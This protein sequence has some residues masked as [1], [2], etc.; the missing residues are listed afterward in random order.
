MFSFK[1]TKSSSTEP[2]ASGWRACCDPICWEAGL[3]GEGSQALSDGPPEPQQMA[4]VS[5]T[6]PQ[7]HREVSI[8]CF[9]RVRYLHEAC[10]LP[11]FPSVAFNK[12]THTHIHTHINTLFA[13]WACRP[14]LRSR[15]GLDAA[16]A[17]GRHQHLSTHSVQCGVLLSTQ[18]TSP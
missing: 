12:S 2:L 6:E 15:P 5:L 10:R 1:P 3:K 14:A 13:A 17:S 11:S 8:N 18:V 4:C 16:P 9:R 7:L